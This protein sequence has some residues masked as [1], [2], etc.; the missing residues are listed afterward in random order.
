MEAVICVNCA[1]CVYVCVCEV[2]VCVYDAVSCVQATDAQL[3]KHNASGY[4]QYDV[5]W[6]V[7]AFV[8][9]EM[10]FVFLN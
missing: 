3:T 6:F 4:G 2:C 8:T 1:V 5:G 9:M 7:K 10:F